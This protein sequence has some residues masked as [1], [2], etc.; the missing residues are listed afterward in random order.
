MTVTAVEDDLH[1]LL[2][3]F[4]EAVHEGLPCSFTTLRLVWQQLSFS[5]VFHQV[6]TLTQAELEIARYAAWLVFPCCMNESTAA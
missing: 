6:R 1:T 2:R 4:A 5:F 3:A